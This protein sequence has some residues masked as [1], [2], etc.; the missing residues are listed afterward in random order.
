[1]TEVFLPFLIN[2]LGIV[3]SLLHWILNSDLFDSKSKY[4]KFP[5]M[6]GKCEL[7]GYII[8]KCMVK[9]LNKYRC[10]E[11]IPAKN[12]EKVEILTGIRYAKV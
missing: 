12:E 2:R 8:P 3:R 5:V 7:I 1:M 6:H 9:T 4:K 11:V 10:V